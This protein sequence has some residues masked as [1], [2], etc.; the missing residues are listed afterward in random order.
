MPETV[1]STFQVFSQYL[2]SELIISDENKLCKDD[3]SHSVSDSFGVPFSNG[4]AVGKM[5]C[6][7]RS[8]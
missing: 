7:D 4:R 5:S 6:G 3:D 2:L 8:E 1:P